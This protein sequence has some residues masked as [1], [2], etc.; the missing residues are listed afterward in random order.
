MHPSFSLGDMLRQLRVERGLTQQQ[1]ARRLGLS[2]NAVISRL[3]R[4]VVLPSEALRRKL[5]RLLGV[6][7]ALLAT[8]VQRESRGATATALLADLSTAFDAA[9]QQLEGEL[10]ALRRSL[11]QHQARIA[12]VLTLSELQLL[13][14]LPDKLAYEATVKSA[15]VVTPDLLLDVQR[16]A[17]RKVVRDNVAR[18]VEYRYLVPPSPGVLQRARR[19]LKDFG[20]KAPVE[21]RSAPADGLMFLSEVVLYDALTPQRLGLM[22]APTARSDVDCVLSPVHAARLARGFQEVWRTAAR[23]T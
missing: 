4:G 9:H 17:L 3:E 18:G 16:D 2:G 5:A 21:V 10:G 20:P 13:W 1:V 14:G 6:E 15:W 23:V 19:F 7:P 12:H 22:V 11:A 8:R